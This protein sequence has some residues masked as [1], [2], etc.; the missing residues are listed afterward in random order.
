MNTSIVGQLGGDYCVVVRTT[1]NSEI[2]KLSSNDSVF[3]E[4]KGI[5]GCKW[6]DHARIQKIAPNVS[7]EFLVNDEGY[8][9]WGTDPNKVNQIG[10]FLYNGGHAPDHY[11]LGDIVI[12]LLVDT[13]DGGEFVGMSEAFATRVALQNNQKVLNLAREKCPIPDE[14]PDP[15]VKISS[16]KTVEDMFRAMNGDKSVNP[17]SEKI[18]SGGGKN[19]DEE[20][21]KNNL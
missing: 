8:I 2:R 20:A 19:E 18:I 12:C 1:G 14:I 9:Q 6:L 4:S 15:V 13:D 10:T 5:I 11:I 16:Y 21:T 3:D 7:L 17:V